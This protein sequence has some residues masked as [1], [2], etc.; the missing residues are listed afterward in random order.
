MIFLLLYYFTL[1]IIYFGL[2]AS[3][4]QIS[5]EFMKYDN[6]NQD[7]IETKNPWSD[8]DTENF[9]DNLVVSF[10]YELSSLPS[11][12]KLRLIYFIMIVDNYHH[13]SLVSAFD[14]FIDASSL[15]HI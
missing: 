3:F 15:S 7:G 11:S 4:Q 14:W 5:F 6:L 13:F 2:F 9:A 12:C 8:V 1:F 10:E